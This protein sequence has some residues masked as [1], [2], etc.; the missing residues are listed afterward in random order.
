MAGQ[1]RP[2][3]DRD[4]GQFIDGF[5]LIVQLAAQIFSFFGIEFEGSQFHQMRKQL[6]SYLVGHSGQY[7]I[8][9]RPLCYNRIHP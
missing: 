1:W 2:I 8:A 9:A 6:W 5:E 4:G 7:T 3:R